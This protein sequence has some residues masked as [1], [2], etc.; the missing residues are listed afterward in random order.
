[1]YKKGGE[2]MDI[3]SAHIGQIFQCINTERYKRGLDV[4]GSIYYKVKSTTADT[5]VLQNIVHPEY[6]IEVSD[7]NKN[8]FVYLLDYDEL[9]EVPNTLHKFFNCEDLIPIRDSLES[10]HNFTYYIR[11]G[12]DINADK[13]YQMLLSLQNMQ[14]QVKTILSE[15]D[16]CKIELSLQH[17]ILINEIFTNF[18]L[19]V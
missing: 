13:L 19:N 6:E 17:K 3:Q 12:T 8:D 9:I 15:L 1:M 4:N 16:K 18:N 5:F 7:Q 11:D 14:N 2:I 10:P